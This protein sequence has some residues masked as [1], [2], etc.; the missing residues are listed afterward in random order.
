MNKEEYERRLL[1][2]GTKMDFSKAKMK[3]EGEA[4]LIKLQGVTYRTILEKVRDSLY[5]NQETTYSIKKLYIKQGDKGKTIYV[6][7]ITYD[8]YTL[9]RLMSLLHI[10]EP[11]MY[12][13]QDG[14]VERSVELNDPSLVTTVKIK[15]GASIRAYV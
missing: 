12:L 7:D 8:I 5:K 11:T 6:G 10:S 15:K 9:S 3:A 14:K 1:R 4:L 13:V 2:N